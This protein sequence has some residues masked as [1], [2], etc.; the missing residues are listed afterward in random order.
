MADKFRLFIDTAGK[1]SDEIK[2]SVERLLKNQSQPPA[3]EEIADE[4]TACEDTSQIRMKIAEVVEDAKRHAQLNSARTANAE[5]IPPRE[6][7]NISYIPNSTPKR[8]QADEIAYAPDTIAAPVMT[9]ADI[10]INR[11]ISE[12]RTLNE[13]FY[14]GYMVQQCGELSIVRQGE[15]MA[16]VTDNFDRKAFCGISR[17]IYGALSNS[18][19][20]TYFTWRTKVRN[21]L[22]EDTDEPYIVLYCYELLNKIGV[23]SSEDAFAKL[24]EIHRRCKESERRYAMIASYLP[25]W[26]RDFYAFNDISGEFPLKWYRNS[27]GSTLDRLTCGVYEGCLDYLISISSYNLV[28]SRFY[29]AETRPLLDGAT[30]AALSR[31]EK[32]FDSKG[33]A[34]FELICGK[35]KKDY[36][37]EP[38]RGAYVNL[39]RMDGFR[40]VKIDATERFCIRRGEPALEVFGITHY[41]GFV[42]YLLKSVEAELRV[43]TGSRNKI[44]ANLAIAQAD[45]ANREKL[46]CAINEDFAQEIVA[47]VDE[48]CDKNNVFPPKKERKKPV[49]PPPQ[50]PEPV[51]VEIDLSRLGEIRA[52]SDELARRLI[53]D[54]D[55]TNYE[56]DEITRLSEQLA[57]EDFSEQIDI[58]GKNAQAAECTADFSTLPA[59]FA[60]LGEALTPQHIKLL[61]ALQNGTAD[62]F[63]RSNGLMPEAEYEK[64]NSLSL[65]CIG[66]IVIENGEIIP[67][68]F[69]DISAII[70]AAGLIE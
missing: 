47:A 54:E 25:Q 10:E 41:R 45:F 38:F 43:R 62:S 59:E 24:L 14:N 67:D 1:S 68:Y 36:D 60:A 66:D 65:E 6:R 4:E 26:L 5:K 53:V 34:L 9:P 40:S 57:A 50:M 64:I 20:R 37:W 42:G 7:S 17:P 19:L 33:I 18:Q 29:N 16:D 35:M 61:D 39:D 13:I 30:A 23:I 2:K 28:G 49:P 46:L 63:C 8:L 11:K 69:E 22:W 70:S 44:S 27:E 3:P 21:G 12:M 51:R 58:C 55:D 15:F 56:S 32:Y 48:W 31:L 52:Q